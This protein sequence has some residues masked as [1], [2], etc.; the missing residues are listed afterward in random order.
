MT[1]PRIIFAS[2]LAA[3]CLLGVAQAQDKDALYTSA[4]AATCASCHGSQGRA[5]AGSSVPGLAG[6]PAP[7]FVAKMKAYK[8]GAL[9]ATIMHQLSKGYSD[10]QIEQL[11][12]YFAAQPVRP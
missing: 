8:S 11:A 5:I 4:L 7:Q 3:S 10:A 2:L 12:A 6:Q 1:K 9:P